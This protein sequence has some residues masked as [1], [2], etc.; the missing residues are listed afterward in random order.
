M[1]PTKF[2]IDKNLK[3]PK[4][5]T[6]ENKKAIHFI[7]LGGIGMSGLA[8][9]LLELGY[10]VTGSDIK[11]N[12]NMFSISALGGTTFIGHNAKNICNAGLVV[13]SS[14]IKIDN[15][16]L[17]EAK[18]RGVPILHRS[19]ILEALMSGLGLVKKQVSIGI[20]GTHGKTTTTGM[21]SLIFEAAKQNPSIV[22]GGQMP[23]LNTNSKLGNGKYF[24]A[25]LDESDGTIEFYSPNYTVIT[26]LELDHHDHYTEGFD[27]LIN[28]FK[29]YISNL[30][31]NAKIILNADCTGN[32]SLFEK[33]NHSGIILYSTNEENKNHEK[34][35]YKAKNIAYEGYTTC[36]DVYKANEFIG[37]IKLGVPGLHNLSNAIAA[38]A[39]ALEN[40]I[41]FEI[42]SKTL[43]QFT[44]MKRR[45]QTVGEVDGI[46]IIDDYAHHPTE[47]KATLNSAKQVVKSLEKGRV[48]AVFQPHRYSRLSNLWNEFSESFENAHKV[49]I[50]DVYSA[51]ES[52]KAGI[53]AEIFAKSINNADTQ[54]LNGS[55]E[56]VAI[57]L[58]ETLR[59]DDLVLTI[60]AGDITKLGNLLVEKLNISR[61][62]KCLQN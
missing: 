39:I 22:V 20:S 44:G 6:K 45:F 15:P 30:D 56:Q 61:Q 62:N 60:G 31:K 32:M 19:Q 34:A 51:G 40:D 11:D 26:N 24:I 38:T 47:L 42:I 50:T 25:E 33:I 13:V 29:T 36:A 7:G 52:P 3:F 16:E 1:N 46:K 43:E 35:L 55:L 10:K 37:K 48:I 23:V 14:A 21:V 5:V 4:C 17:I 53:N 9:F 59:P 58:S 8:K 49:Y 12:P 41:D 18:N 2:M 27:Q 54:Y 28:T 57:K